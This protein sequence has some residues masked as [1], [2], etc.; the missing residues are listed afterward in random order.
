MNLPWSENAILAGIIPGP[1]DPDEDM[2]SFLEPL[3]KELQSLWRGIEMVYLSGVT[4]TVRCALV[5]VACDLPA[6]RKVCWVSILYCKVWLLQEDFRGNV[7]N[8]GYSGFDRDNWP[9]RAQSVH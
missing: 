9:T 1:D 2:N 4:T 6:G 3:V 8:K 5:C 7:G